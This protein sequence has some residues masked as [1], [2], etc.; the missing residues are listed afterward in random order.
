VR[1]LVLTH[2]FPPVGG[3]GGK[4]AE[5]ICRCL[6]K[7]GHEV[8]V[9]TAYLKGLP[10]EES[11]D[12]FQVQ[13]ISSMRRQA[14]RAD[15]RAMSGY[16]F[17]GFFA[18]IRKMRL[19]RPDILHAHFAV[20]SGA[21]AWLLNRLTGIPYIITA[22]LGD[23]PGGVPEKTGR[24]FRWIYPFTPA[25]WRSSAQ[26]V[27]VSEFTRQLAL[28]HYPVDIRVIPNGVDLERLNPSEIRLSQPRRLVFAGRFVPQ[29]AP[30]QLVQTLA[31]LRD[32]PWTCTMLGDGPLRSEVEN[33]V[34]RLGLQE[35]IRL[36]G[37]VT[38][39]E[40]ITEFAY[41]DILFMPS[42]SEGLSV[43]G[44]QALA[45]GLAIVA[46][47]IGGFLD[48]VDHGENGFLHV[49]EDREGFAD[50]LKKLLDDPELLYQ[51]RQ[52]SRSK[53]VAFDIGQVGKSYEKV[54]EQV[55]G[56]Q[57]GN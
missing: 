2:E 45:M 5:D 34:A 13:R 38:P 29:K 23:V 33:E 25:I 50:S 47:Q 11:L 1:I 31:H 30:L 8:K 18:G 14:Y 53:A 9:L 37:W 32:L 41:S 24:W 17:A 35:R 12:G 4:A 42:L 22:H 16:I 48:L 20:P 40:V 46:S 6:A 56:K 39:E 49:P 57:D 54:F 52:N 7:H 10:K 19:W 43:V 55:V 26:V 15:L 36:P 3:G 51:F 27:A 28:S 44:V 21:L